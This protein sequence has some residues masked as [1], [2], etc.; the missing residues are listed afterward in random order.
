M[1]RSLELNTLRIP[2]KREGSDNGSGSPKIA[3]SPLPEEPAKMK[4]T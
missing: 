2:D 1:D 3:G 4:M